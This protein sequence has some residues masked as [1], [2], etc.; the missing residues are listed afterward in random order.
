[1]TDSIPSSSQLIGYWDSSAES[2]EFRHPLPDAVIDKYFPADGNVLDIGCGQ[3][4]L[5]AYLAEKG[6]SVSGTDTSPAML[7]QAK[8]NAPNCEFRNCRSELIWEDNTFDV[9]LLVTLLTSVP[10]DLEQRQIMAEVKRV[11]KPGG[12]LFVSDLPMQWSKRYLDRYAD[13]LKRYGQYGVFDIEDGGVVRHH[14]MTYFMKLMARFDCQEIETHEVTTMTG[15]QAEA[16]RYV[17]KL[18]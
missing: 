8:K 7:E 18:A 9:V 6:F 5:A 14:E 10:M 4:R 16:I 15:N 3:G 11:L 13:G 2:K 12:Y 1:M 17:G